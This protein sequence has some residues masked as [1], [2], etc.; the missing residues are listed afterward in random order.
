[1]KR[2]NAARS[3]RRRAARSMRLSCGAGDDLW[4]A[5]FVNDLKKISYRAEE[6]SEL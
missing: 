1:M 6:L 2:S 3:V 4:L 5:R